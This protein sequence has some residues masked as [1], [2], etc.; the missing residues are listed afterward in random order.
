MADSPRRLHQN[1]DIG[2]SNEQTKIV[3]RTEAGR[4][5][6]CEALEGETLFSTLYRVCMLTFMEL[7]AVLKHSTAKKGQI[8]ITTNANATP[9]PIEGKFNEQ[10]RKRRNSTDSDRPDS[11]KKQGAAIQIEIRMV[12]AI[13]TTTTT[14]NFF[15]PLRALEI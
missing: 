15:A 8:G 4:V 10:E 3:K 13:T 14:K 5:S 12:K 11:A 9:K 6:L 1:R 2:E 7:K